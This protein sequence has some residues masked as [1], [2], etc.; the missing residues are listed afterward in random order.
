MEEQCPDKAKVVGSNPTEP[1]KR[2]EGNIM[3]IRI[4]GVSPDKTDCLA[5]LKTLAGE[6]GFEPGL[7][8]PEP[9]VLPLDDS[10]ATPK[11]S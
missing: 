10:P 5:K 3:G 7:H 6:P 9:C 11:S 8:G 1:T 2:L 4:R